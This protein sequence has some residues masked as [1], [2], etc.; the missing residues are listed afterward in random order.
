MQYRFGVTQARADYSKSHYSEAARVDYWFRYARQRHTRL[1]AEYG[2]T[3]KS[4]DWYKHES[5]ISSQ[6]QFY[7]ENGLVRPGG[8][9][10]ELLLSSELIFSIVAL[11]K[12]VL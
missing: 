12:F 10:V 4:T 8:K 3:N 7:S 6:G 5:I 11:L 9:G 2:R 1:Q